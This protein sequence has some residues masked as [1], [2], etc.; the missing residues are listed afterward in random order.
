MNPTAPLSPPDR[1]LVA[2]RWAA[3]VAALAAAGAAGLAGSAEA[4]E[5]ALR[6]GLAASG[7]EL[8]LTVMF[9]QWFAALVNV[10]SVVGLSLLL[11]GLLWFAFQLV[12]T[13]HAP[14]IR[15]AVHLVACLAVVGL[16]VAGWAA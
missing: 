11:G 14:T 3:F 5:H 1:R 8:E 2:G 10:L 6:S 9:A 4:R 13:R 12:H 15:Q 16:V 7:D